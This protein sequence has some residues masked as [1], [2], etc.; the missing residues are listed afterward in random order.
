MT[1]PQEHAGWTTRAPKWAAVGVLGIASIV[2]IAYSM[3]RQGRVWRPAPGETV[4]VQPSPRAESTPDASTPAS[5]TAAKPAATS[6]NVRSTINLNT[7]TQAELELLPGI[8]P[9]LA[10][11][12]IEQRALRG[13]FKRVEDLDTVK[14]IGPK[15]MDRLRPLVRVE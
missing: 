13:V 3:T 7:A 14:G 12:I 15:M 4:V 6:A 5:T 11:R 10:Q 9:A 1:S 8:G 2:G